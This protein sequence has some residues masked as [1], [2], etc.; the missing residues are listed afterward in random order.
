MKAIDKLNLVNR[1]HQTALQIA[2][3]DKPTGG[4]WRF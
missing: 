4:A 3:E 2:R 1:I